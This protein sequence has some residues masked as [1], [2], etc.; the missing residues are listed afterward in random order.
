MR[1]LAYAN[2]EAMCLDL[3]VLTLIRACRRNP[4]WFMRWPRRCSM[5][6]YG[7]T[8]KISK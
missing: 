4:R 1:L 7:D 5:V 8:K 2:T 6:T 3:D